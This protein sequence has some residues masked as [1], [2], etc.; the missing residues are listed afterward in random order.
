MNIFFLDQDP[1]L[2]AQALCDRHCVKMILETAQ[3]LS[4]AIHLT[5]GETEGLYGPTHEG[6]PCT[7]WTAESRQN[8]DWLKAHGLALSSEYTHRYGKV[9][10]SAATI[11]SCSNTSIP[12]TL[13]TP[14]VLAMPDFCRLV[15]PVEAYKMYYNVVKYRIAV[16]TNRDIPIWFRPHAYIGRHE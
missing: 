16:W 8:F 11:R 7:E 3:L 9:H 4:T 5:G 10:L 14:P 2:A 15:D 12:D 6:H 13:A 1:V